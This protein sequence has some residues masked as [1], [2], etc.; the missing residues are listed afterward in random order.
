MKRYDTLLFDVYRWVEHPEVKELYSLLWG[1]IPRGGRHEE[2][3]EKMAECL[4][5]VLCNLAASYYVGKPLAV[6][7]RCSQFSSGR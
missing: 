3:F 4:K 2:T 6:P 1:A 5:L 7:M